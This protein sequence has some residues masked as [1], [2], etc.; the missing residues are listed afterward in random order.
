VCVMLFIHQGL[1][2][3]DKLPS[4]P[5][6]LYRWDDWGPQHSRMVMLERFEPVWVCYVHGTRF[7]RNL[8]IVDRVTRAVT[9]RL[10]IWDF[11]Q[12]S[13]R[14]DEDYGEQNVDK[15]TIPKGYEL[16]ANDVTTSL[17]FRRSTGPQKYPYS[18]FMIDED[19]VIGLHR[20]HDLSS[21]I[22]GERDI[23]FYC[24]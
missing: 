4:Q 12:L 10:E 1:L 13:I 22:N 14:R 15:S 20:L 9:S 7:V 17:P 11:N 19:V 2:L 21:P 6:N 16:F 24:V 18:D 8:P 3:S 23:T 5:S